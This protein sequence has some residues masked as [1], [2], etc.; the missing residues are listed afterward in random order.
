MKPKVVIIIL[1]WR[2]P[3]ETIACLKSLAKLN[4]PNFKIILIDNGSRDGS[5]V[6]LDKFLDGFSKPI[7]FIKN[8]ENL[9]YSGG[10]NQG[11]KIA[12]KENPDYVLLLNN[13]TIVPPDFLKKMIE[14]AE[15]NPKIGILSPK[16]YNL[17]KN[18]KKV[19][20]AGGK[21]NWIL[22]KA[23]HI[24]K[25]IKNEKPK[26]SIVPG[27]AMLIKK[28]VF[29]ELGLLPEEYFFYL[30]DTDFCLRA[31]KKGWKVIYFP[32]AHI[33]HKAEQ[34]HSLFTLYYYQRNRILLT[35]KFAPRYFLPLTYT[36][37]FFKMIR[38]FFSYLLGYQDSRIILKAMLAGL[39]GETGRANPS[40]WLGVKE[41]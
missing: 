22:G 30:E 18:A 7:Q 23:S 4:Y 20:F 16:I 14:F 19:W 5:F 37:W 12:L 35:K 26:E 38:H 29:A 31:Q 6:K 13:D 34:K 40:T 24:G 10:N 25:E 3:E 17:V 32:N 27:C 8:K 41:F 39:R 1:N 9:G 36:Y 28:A 33:F 11:I 15:K 21:I 2:S